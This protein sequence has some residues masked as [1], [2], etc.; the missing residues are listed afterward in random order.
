MKKFFKTRGRGWLL[1]LIA[2]VAIAGFF[3]VRSSHASANAIATAE[4]RRGDFVEYLEVRGE[5]KA[6]DSKTL[7][8]PSG[9][10]DL[11]ILKLAHT[12]AQVKKGDI[13]LQFDST[14]LQR[15]LEQKQSELASAEAEIR[16]Q[17][18]TEHM[19]QEQNLTDSLSA[20]FN[21]ESARLDVSK[22]EILSQIDGEKNKLA[23]ADSQQKLKES[24]IKLDSG[25]LGS[26]A[27]IEM[28][29]KKRDKAR[30]DVETAERQIAS[31]TV[32]APSDGVVTI[33]SNDRAS[34]FGGNAPDFREGDRAWPDAAILE[35]PNLNS[36]R[37]V[38][39]V[40]EADRGQLNVGQ[41]G[42]V[43]VDAVPDTEFS[44]RVEDIGRLAKLDWSG[45]PPIKDFDLTVS[46]DR[47]D[48]RLRP[49]MKANTRIAVDSV[50]NSVLVPA[51]AVF[52]HNGRAVVYVK[53]GRDFVERNIQLGRRSGDT[54]QVIA[55]LHPGERVALKDLGQEKEKVS[56]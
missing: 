17:Q 21:V 55:G 40:D 15:T 49:G 19:T 45:W 31:L 24:Q 35:I 20:K 8:A 10:G 3:A 53:E 56:Q 39:H 34:N 28:K 38:A 12:G 2:V 5:I 47:T 26:A 30:F 48:P 36:I 29:K 41:T 54:A 22:A 42:T 25:K 44:A 33:L 4:V 32:R 18:A 27:D 9:A 6:S 50:A 14:K 1:A 43:H 46:M 11:Q 52:Q 51:P 37:M 16:Q 13:V 7:I 23:L